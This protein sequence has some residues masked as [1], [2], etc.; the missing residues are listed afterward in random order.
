MMSSTSNK[1][2]VGQTEYISPDYKK[3]ICM[4]KNSIEDGKIKTV[5]A[6]KKYLE[7]LLSCPDAE[8]IAA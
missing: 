4:I 5:D 2:V 8:A 3:H 6:A 1:Y 7:A